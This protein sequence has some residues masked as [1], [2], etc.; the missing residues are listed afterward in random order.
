MFVCAPCKMSLLQNGDCDGIDLEWMYG[1]DS[2]EDS[3]DDSGDVDRDGFVDLS[4]LVLRRFLNKTLKI[5]INVFTHP[6]HYN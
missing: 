2:D 3:I 5:Q 4:S 1:Q 6:T